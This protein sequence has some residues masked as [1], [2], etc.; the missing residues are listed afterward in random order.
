MSSDT[1]VSYVYNGTRVSL[2]NYQKEENVMITPTPHLYL[3]KGPSRKTL[4]FEISARQL[5]E[6]IRYHLTS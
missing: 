2:I 1:S 5:F 6:E 3:S 4:K